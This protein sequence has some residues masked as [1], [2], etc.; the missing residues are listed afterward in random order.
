MSRFNERGFV[1]TVC[2]Y[3]ANLNNSSWRHYSGR[4]RVSLSWQRS[5]SV[6]PSLSTLTITLWSPP[7]SDRDS[8]WPSVLVNHLWEAH[9][10]WSATVRERQIIQR[11]FTSMHSA[12]LLTI[13]VEVIRDSLPTKWTKRKLTPW[14][15]RNEERSRTSP[16]VNASG[17]FL[18]VLA[19]KVARTKFLLAGRRVSS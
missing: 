8:P 7:V 16:V 13:D 3:I 14:P 11:R 9:F 10:I 2:M 19:R 1:S 5:N 6:R 4:D 18:V 17:G 12:M 15:W